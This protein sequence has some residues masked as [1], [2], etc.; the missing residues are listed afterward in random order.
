MPRPE[1]KHTDSP[2]RLAL[3]QA[4][5]RIVFRA[6]YNWLT[7]LLV[8]SGCWRCYAV[9]LAI[10]ALMVWVVFASRYNWLT[11]LLLPGGCWICYAVRIA[12]VIMFG[13]LIYSTFVAFT[14]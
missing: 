11:A 8:P 4:L 6:K 9:R 1:I 13:F 10:I 12:L 7:G 14:S 5:D 3:R 2:K